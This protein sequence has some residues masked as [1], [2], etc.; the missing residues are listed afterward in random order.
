TGR[1][2]RAIAP[3]LR[4]D[5][6]KA[7]AN[8]S[9]TS[10]HAS[11]SMPVP[12]ASKHT[13]STDSCSTANFAQASHNATAKLSSPPD[14]LF[15]GACDAVAMLQYPVAEVCTELRYFVGDSAD[16]RWLTAGQF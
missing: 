14:R 4:R 2:S 13:I 6:N 1:V 7:T 8:E 15:A 12:S 16:A 5:S 9:W 10:R 3:C 11:C